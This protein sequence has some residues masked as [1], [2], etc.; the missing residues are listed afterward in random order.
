MTH[1]FKWTGAAS[2]ARLS[3][4]SPRSGGST[5]GRAPTSPTIGP[6]IGAKH[7]L[8]PI[9][10]DRAAMRR[11]VRER[12]F[13]AS[14][15]D[16][17]EDHPDLVGPRLDLW[18]LIQQTPNLDWLL[19]TKR[20]ENFARFLPWLA[21]VPAEPWPNVWGLVSAEDQ[22]HADMRIP[23]LIE[24]P[25]AVRGVSYEPALGPV[26]LSPW[27][28]PRMTDVLPRCPHEFRI[29][30]GGGHDPCA[31]CGITFEAE[32]ARYS[33][34]VARRLNWIIVGGES[35]LFARACHVEWIRSTV[36]QC[37]RAGVAVFVKQMGSHVVD[38]ND[39]NYDGEHERARPAG[40]NTEDIETG[41]QGAP[42]RVRLDDRK[43]GDPAEWPADLRIREWPQ[44]ALTNRSNEEAP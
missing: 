37:R 32:F 36:A 9:G 44:P 19:L 17:F 40:T 16:V 34:A 4:C 3:R 8:G 42:V 23:P 35:G 21:A 25:F 6:S 29:L 7:W 12:V 26:D 10:W 33:A 28:R 41:Y 11:G 14:M 20:P 2:P 31:N 5:A 27:L 18:A 13:C 22:K 38:L 39:A 1:N 24:A 15:A 30:D 43:G